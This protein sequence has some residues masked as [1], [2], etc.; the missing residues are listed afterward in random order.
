MMWAQPLRLVRMNPQRHYP[1]TVPKGNYSG[2]AWMGGNRYAVV[3]DKAPKSGFFVFEIDVDSVSGGLLGVSAKGFF[4]SDEDNRD[5]E[6][7]AFFAERN[8]VFISREADNKVKEYALDGRATGRE[9]AVPPVFGRAGGNYGLEALTYNRTTHRFWTTSESTLEGDGG[10]ADSRN[11]VQNRLRLQSFGD[12]LSPREQYAYQMDAPAVRGQVASYAM[13]VA[14]MAALD[15]GRLLVLER[16]FVVTS[17]KLGSYV[18]NKLYSVWPDGGK[19]VSSDTVLNAQ[20]PCL[21]KTLLAKWKTSI[22]LFR[23]NLANYEGLCAGPRLK[24]GSQVLLLCADSQNQ[25][26]GILRDWF[27]TIIIRQGPY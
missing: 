18:V 1:A 27:R 17:K 26:G 11:G 19:E 20:S 7:I 5:E 25:Y 8:T 10:R 16:E 24:D 2:M 9:L 13:G 23:Q 15:D 12:D 6:G 14:G 22:T 3:S 4:A 21:G